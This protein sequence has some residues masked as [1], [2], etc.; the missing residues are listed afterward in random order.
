MTEWQR[1]EK[2]EK[3]LYK[4][5]QRLYKRNLEQVQRDIA[6]YYTKYGTGKILEY[7]TL[8]EALTPAERDL[9]YKDWSAFIIQHP[10][11]AHLT[12]IRYNAYKINRLEGLEQNIRMAQYKQ[13]FIEAAEYEKHLSE[14]VKMGYN[15]SLNGQNISIISDSTVKMVANSMYKTDATIAAEFLGKKAIHAD[16]IW[17]AVKDGLVRGD[18]YS[19]MAKIIQERFDVN[20]KDAKRW[21]YTEGTRCI[22]E[23]KARGFENLGYKR[24]IFRTMQDDRVCEICAAID[25]EEFAFE[26]R[27]PGDN[28]PPMH[29]NCRCSIEVVNDWEENGSQEKQ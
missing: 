27:S 21:I 26:D 1:L 24:Y 22:N 12:D 19:N 5:I 25:G 29:A 16:K 6:S 28:F 2:A 18:S 4:N 9:L 8:L 10:E 3:K 17:N 20:Y 14:A 13:G 11:A 7:R 15:A 23:G